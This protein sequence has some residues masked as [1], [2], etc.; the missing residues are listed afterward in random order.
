MKRGNNISSIISVSAIDSSPGFYN[1]I[2]Y[3]TL[4]H[5]FLYDNE[6]YYNLPQSIRCTG[7][8]NADNK[9]IDL[10]MMTYG[11]R[12]YTLKETAMVMQEKR[13]DNYDHLKISNPGKRQERQGSDQHFIS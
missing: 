13:E 7:L 9:T 2:P 3:S 5:S 12:K 11:W 1:V 6:F 10:L 4:S 8:K